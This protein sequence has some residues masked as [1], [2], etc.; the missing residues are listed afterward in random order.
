GGTSFDVC[1]IPGGRPRT[2]EETNLG[3]RL[4]LRVSM[5]D[6]HTI[7]AGGGSIAWI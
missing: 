2:T 6:V 3:F 5:I 4:P 1:L 7:G